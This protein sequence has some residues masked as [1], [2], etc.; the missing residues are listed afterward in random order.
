MCIYTYLILVIFRL[1]YSSL[2]AQFQYLSVGQFPQFVS[3]PPYPAG[4]FY[5]SL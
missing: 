1:G 2:K 4:L 3:W 5:F